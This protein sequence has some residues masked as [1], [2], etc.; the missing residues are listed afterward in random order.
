MNLKEYRMAASRTSAQLDTLWE[1]QIHYLM[2]MMT[3]IGELTDVFKRYLA[4]KQELDMINIGEE[5]G[6]L[7]WYLSNFCQVSDLDLEE[8]LQKNT[9]KLMTRYPDK[10]TEEHAINRDIDKEREI[11]EK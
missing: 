3:G 6:D 7:M 2:G 11:L 9:D 8:I 4:Y 5:I 1:E 10:F